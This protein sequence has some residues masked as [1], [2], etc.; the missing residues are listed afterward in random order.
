MLNII[1]FG[2]HVK[3]C[4]QL[5]TLINVYTDN[6]DSRKGHFLLLLL[7]DSEFQLLFKQKESIRVK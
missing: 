6:G 7:P 3:S 5:F 1:Q 2:S 4:D